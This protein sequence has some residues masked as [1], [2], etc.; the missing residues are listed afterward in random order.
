M[1]SSV[2]RPAI[3]AILAKSQNGCSS[4]S[5][6]ALVAALSGGSRN[7]EAFVTTSGRRNFAAKAVEKKDDADAEKDENAISEV[8][9]QKEKL[10]KK[11]NNLLWE[12]PEA[13]PA[14]YMPEDVTELTAIDPA[15]LHVRT[16]SDGTERFV[17]IRQ[18]KANVKQSPLNEEKR[19]RIQ[20]TE[21]G[22]TADKWTNSLM[23]WTSNA[24][25]F[26]SN[27][28]LY[29]DNAK[30]A[31]QFAK[32]RG[33]RFLVK[34]PI[35]RKLRDDD[36]QY[37]D[38]FLPQIVAAKIAKERTQCDHWYRTEAATSHYFRPVRYHGKGTVRQ[39][40]PNMHAEIAPHADSIY[41]VR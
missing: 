16:A 28:P 24:D 1:I 12:S 20:F 3:R 37:Q 36:V 29:F 41:K 40:G 31:V 26:Q 39:H 25:S 19:W 18:D 9:E 22:V 7:M 15:D 32:K 34:E 23:K 5:K 8:I 30:D 27:P 38:N 11:S 6:T 14:P 10:Q 4:T 17:V 2:C 33:W 21:D 13:I 35:K